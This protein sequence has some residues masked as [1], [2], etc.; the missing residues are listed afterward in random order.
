MWILRRRYNFRWYR[1]RGAQRIIWKRTMRTCD[2]NDTVTTHTSVRY[3]SRV[4]RVRFDYRQLSDLLQMPRS[5]RARC[6][7][8][9]SKDRNWRLIFRFWRT[10]E[11]TTG[12]GGP[13]TVAWEPVGSAPLARP[14][15]PL[16]KLNGT[17]RMNK[18]NSL[19]FALARAL[20]T[21]SRGKTSIR[22]TLINKIFRER[23]RIQFASDFCVGASLITF[24]N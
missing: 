5:G 1:S 18:A 4:K 21:I 22:E 2:V 14:S 13:R 6:R 11:A 23:T 24:I 12:L 17:R 7:A 15:F 8:D 19:P 20:F 10:W 3:W 9:A 16:G